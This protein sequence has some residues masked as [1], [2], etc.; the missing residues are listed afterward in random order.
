MG[1]IINQPFQEDS[2]IE[3]MEIPSSSNSAGK[4]A[5]VRRRAFC[6]GSKKDPRGQWLLMAVYDTYMYTYIYI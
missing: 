6:T 5:F 4:A 1:S 3:A 2:S